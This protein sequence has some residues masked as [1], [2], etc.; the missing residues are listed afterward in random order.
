MAVRRT[1]EGTVDNAEY[2]RSYR[3]TEKHKKYTWTPIWKW[4]QWKSRLWYR[5]RVT[6]EW[7]GI[8]FLEQ[9][10][11]CAI[12]K[13]DIHY[14]VWGE[15][16]SK[17]FSIHIDHNHLTGEP[18]GLLCQNCNIAIGKLQDDKTIILEA[19]NYVS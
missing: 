18:R 1:I 4:G 9:Q 13:R 3:K 2:M 11:K 12:C 16:L 15:R 10:G 7:V 5:Y 8:K 17:T 19:Y 14:N 6:P